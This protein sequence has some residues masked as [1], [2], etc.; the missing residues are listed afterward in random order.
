MENDT[1]T[2]GYN[3]WFYFAL[4]NA[5]TN[6]KYQFHVVNYVTPH[7]TQRKRLRFFEE[8]QRIVLFSRS[9]AE[10]Y[11]NGWRRAGNNYSIQ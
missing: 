4:R 2:L 6:V 5:R 11:K 7:T 9:D 10:Q 1:N 3:Q 8:G